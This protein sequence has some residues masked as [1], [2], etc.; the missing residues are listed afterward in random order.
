MLLVCLDLDLLHNMTRLVQIWRYV[1]LD[2][3][4][5]KLAFTHGFQKRIPYLMRF[6][7]TCPCQI[8]SMLWSEFVNAFI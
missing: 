6:L 7:S 8:A 2:Q 4:L 3:N 1:K 5:A